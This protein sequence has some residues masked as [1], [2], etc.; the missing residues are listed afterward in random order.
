MKIART[1]R[2]ALWLILLMASAVQPALAVVIG[3]GD[4]SGNARAPVDDPGWSHVGV[5]GNNSGVHLRDHWVITA[6]HIGAREFR[7]GDRLFEAVQ[8]K[9]R[10]RIYTAPKMEADLQMIQL[11]KSPD[12]PPLRLA[13]S[14][15]L[16][17]TPVLMV[18]HGLE[19][20]PSRSGWSGIWAPVPL[21]G[22]SYAGYQTTQE[23]SLRWGT[24]HIAAVDLLARTGKRVSRTFAT[25]F[26]GG[27]PTPHEAQAAAGDSGGP[28]FASDGTGQWELAGVMITISKHESQPGNLTVY[29]N[30]TYAV[31]IHAYRDQIE[32]ILASSPDHDRDGI[33][34]IDDNC[35]RV[36]N[37]DQADADGD[38]TGDVCEEP[39]E[40]EGS[41]GKPKAGRKGVR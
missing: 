1:A 18:G 28:V 25:S 41:A 17:E 34:D 13:S 36:K 37:P 39:E 21:A 38:G 19:R 2:S 9:I 8:G 24:N 26:D 3:S 7:L 20:S 5:L 27:L 4:G 33:L 32:K 40:A 16:I 22:A 31:D 30:V 29:G 10:H 23:R 15:P 6:G 14:A 35:T 12:L 11:R